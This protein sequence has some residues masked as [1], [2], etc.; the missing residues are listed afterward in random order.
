MPL[1]HIVISG[2]VQG[3]FFRQSAKRE[4]EKLGIGGWARNNSDGSVEIEAEGDKAQLEEFI[5]WCKKGP[6][7]A[8]VNNVEVEWSDYTE[9]FEEFSIE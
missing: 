5:K 3:V 1:V 8:F 2:R 6:S 4:A 9:G 7:V